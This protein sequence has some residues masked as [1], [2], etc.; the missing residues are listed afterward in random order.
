MRR[1]AAVAASALARVYHEGWGNRIVGSAWLRRAAALLDGEPP[2][3]EQGW[4]AVGL[5]GC[6]ISDAAVLEAKARMA[7]DVA[8]RFG[9][10]RLEAQALA[11]SGL[12]LVSFGQIDEGM[13]RLDEAMTLTMGPGIGD[14]VAISMAGCC[15]FTACERAGDLAR[16]EA[17]L[18]I[19]EE[20]G[21]YT[22]ENALAV[23]HC[24]ATYG[25]PL[26][27]FGRW[28][29]AEPLLV[30]GVEAGARSGHFFSRLEARAALAD[31]R[32]QQGR[33]AEAEQLLLGLD[34]RVEALAP[35]A[36]LYGA[37][38][39]HELAVAVARRG[40]RLL[41]ADRLRAAPLLLAAVAA[42][43]GRGDLEAAAATAAELTG[44]AT[45]AGQPTPIAQAAL[46]TAR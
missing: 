4:V 39:D 16:A 45:K 17:W 44:V 29:E 24:G 46:A 28:Q 41:G 14:P 33:L 30:A 32:I 36:R 5:I 31:L 22:P 19:T 15:M 13:G 42:E 20:L 23:A 37:R 25:A 43:L 18:R 8:R 27:E 34:D 21:I 10:L 2:C 6:D 38:G 35:L 1:R 7:L 3:V 12:A 26:R 11:D 9:D 40:V